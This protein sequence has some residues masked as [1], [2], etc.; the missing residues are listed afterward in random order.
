MN[1][2]LRQWQERALNKAMDWL[3]TEKADKHFLINAAPGAG[4]TIASCAI[5]QTLLTIG[6]I[7]RVI[8][9]APRSEI[10]NQCAKDFTFVTGLHMAKVTGADGEISE[11]S[12]DVCATWSA[13]QSLLP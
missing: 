9:I 1:I 2:R 11:L 3:V 10:V 6:E 8:V 5:A 4:K 13:I 7:D 12:L